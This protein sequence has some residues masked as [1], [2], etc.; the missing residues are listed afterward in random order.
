MNG[1]FINIPCVPGLRTLHRVLC[2]AWCC[3]VARLQQEHHV[4]RAKV[5]FT[6]PIIRGWEKIREMREISLIFFV[7]IY[8]SCLLYGSLCITHARHQ[9]SSIYSSHLVINNICNIMIFAQKW[10]INQGSRTRLVRQ[11]QSFQDIGGWSWGNWMWV[12]EKLGAQ[13]ILWYWNSA[14]SSYNFSFFLNTIYFSPFINLHYITLCIF[15][16]IF[17]F[18]N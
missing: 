12:I 15:F 14:L 1:V 9:H 4:R 3:C 5:W 7:F 13:W 11:G 8:S 10:A 18:Q 2:V 6:W 17:R 16:Y